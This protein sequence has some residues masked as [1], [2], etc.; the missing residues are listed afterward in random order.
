MKCDSCHKEVYGVSIY[1]IMP[2]DRI[3]GREPARVCMDCTDAC[4]CGKK[5]YWYD[6]MLTCLHGFTYT[7]DYHWEGDKAII[8]Q[9]LEKRKWWSYI[10]TTNSRH[11]NLVIT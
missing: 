8:D 10:I 11:E 9:K 4:P 2:W 1:G 5:G 3:D 7:N 6:G